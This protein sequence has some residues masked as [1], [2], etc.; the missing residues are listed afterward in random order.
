MP[1]WRL[2]TKCDKWKISLDV[3]MD[4]IWWKRTESNYNYRR[5]KD[6]KYKKE[7]KVA[8]SKAKEGGNGIPKI[9]E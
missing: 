1:L 7:L 5:R 6:R 4:G 3:V 2:L 8:R 9:A